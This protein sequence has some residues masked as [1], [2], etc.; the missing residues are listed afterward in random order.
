MKRESIRTPYATY[1]IDAT[2]A[3]DGLPAAP[4]EPA[5]RAG[6]APVLS[7]SREQTPLKSLDPALP[8][9]YP[10]RIL[11][12]VT[13]LSPQVAT[14]TLYALA[15]KKELPFVPTEIHL[16]TTAEG[17]ERAR[18]SLLHEKSGW[19]PKLCRDYSLKD[20]QFDEEGLHILKNNEGELL[21]DIRTPI[22]NERAADAITEI[23]RKLTEDPQSAL[24][25]SIAGG[26]KTMGFYLGYALSLFGRP[27]DRLSH[28]LVNAPYE[29][30]PDFYY[31]TPE[32]HV[33]Y[34][35]G[36]DSKPLD[37]QNA[38][39]TLAEIPFVRLR[40]GLPDELL[41]GRVQF[42]KTVVAVQR[43]V[44]PPELVIDTA[45]CWVECGGQRIV[46]K[47]A[48]QAFLSWFAHRAM[49][50]KPGIFR[51]G[52]TNDEKEEYLNEYRRLRGDF[53]GSVEQLQEALKDGLDE[54]YFDQRRSRL[55]AALDRALGKAVAR[56]YYVHSDRKRPTSR[57]SMRL[58]P[59]QIRISD[60]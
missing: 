32:S 51:S 24:H 54:D 50:E 2:D 35:P 14:E 28:V 58:S 18:L 13:G 8:H 19:Y 43:N 59:G 6:A 20:I 57:Y 26:R 41:T 10:R 45:R 15:V 22:D 56:D 25:V 47:P 40:H 5:A 36:P 39:V 55:H 31:P 49:E 11:L 17:A 48:D 38:N 52:V 9:T 44:G 42:S 60:R 33:I 3:R 29:S 16:I 23:V 37:T 12:A 4:Q 46:M 34:T 53:S 30:H 27:Q 1:G 21:T 7:N